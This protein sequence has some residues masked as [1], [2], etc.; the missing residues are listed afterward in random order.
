MPRTKTSGIRT[1]A[2]GSKM[3]DKTV[4]GE[5]IFRRLGAVSQEEAETWLSTQIERIRLS[6]QSGVRPRVIFRE[7]AAKYL[8]DN[9]KKKSI[10]TIA[11]HLEQLDPFIGDL[12][13]EEIHDATL[14]PFIEHRLTPTINRRG[15]EKRLSRSKSAGS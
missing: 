2:D 7:A 12:P 10:D 8:A 11:Y 15:K 5:R 13:L 6:K 3:V 4:Q 14:E 9:L 1:D